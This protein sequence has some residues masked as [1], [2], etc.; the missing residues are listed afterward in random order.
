VFTDQPVTPAPADSTD[1]APAGSGESSIMD[2][3]APVTGDDTQNGQ[4]AV[5]P[6]EARRDSARRVLA[7]LKAWESEGGHLAR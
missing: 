6:A 3:P 2:A 7:G 1:P 5:T 4:P